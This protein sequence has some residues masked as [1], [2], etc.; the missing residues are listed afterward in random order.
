MWVRMLEEDG[1]VVGIGEY[2]C[3]WMYFDWYVVH[4][5]ADKDR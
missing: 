5:E 2:V 1:D 4:E 3:V